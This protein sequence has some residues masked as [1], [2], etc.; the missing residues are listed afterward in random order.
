MSLNTY[1]THGLNILVDADELS[2]NKRKTRSTPNDPLVAW[3]MGNVD[4]WEQ[5]RNSNY[6]NGDL[7]S[8]TYSQ[9]WDEYWR[10]FRTEWSGED[11]QRS[12][13]RSRIVPST[14]MQA[15]DSAVAELQE[16]TFSR[17]A[18]FDTADDVADEARE[19]ITLMA[20]RLRE[21]MDFADVPDEIGKAYLYAA[22]FGTGIL[23]VTVSTKPEYTPQGMVMRDGSAVLGIKSSDIVTVGAV[24]VSPREFVIDP[25]ASI[26]DEALG[27]AHIVTVPTHTVHEK[28]Q[29]G[30]YARVPLGTY[31]QEKQNY[32]YRESESNIQNKCKLVEYHGLVPKALLPN[33]KARPDTMKAAAEGKFDYKTDMVEAIVVIANDAACL[34]AVETPFVK[35][36]DRSIVAFQWDNIPDRFWGRGIIERGYH[37]H[38]ALQTEI[39]AR[40]DSLAL[41]SYPMMARDI[42]SIT[43]DQVKEGPQAGIVQPGREIWVSGNPNEQLREFRFSGPDPNTYRATADYERMIEQATGTLSYGGPTASAVNSTVGGMSMAMG[44]FL[45][46]TK[47]TAYNV[48]RNLLK[49]LVEK[50]AFRYMQFRPD[51]YP[52]QD[53]KFK[54]LGTMGIMAREAEQDLMAQILRTVPQDSPAYYVILRLILENGALTEKP[55]LLAVVDALLQASLNPPPAPPDLSGEARMLSAQQRVQEHQD[56]VALRHEELKRKDAELMLRN[57]E[58]ELV[59][60]GRMAQGIVDAAKA[61]SEAILNIAKAEAAEVG[62]QVEQYKAIVESLA[63]T[64]MQVSTGVEPTEPQKPEN[65]KALEEKIEGLLAEVADLRKIKTTKGKDNAGAPITIQR[66]Q[67]G[68]VTSINGRKAK[69]D[70]NGL[71]VGL[72]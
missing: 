3:V 19:D 25:S 8:A 12:I 52:V 24:A 32:N 69:R 53:F 28:Q 33:V 41:S 16:A 46:R 48:E 44:S 70:A 4:E 10:I 68:L 47:K 66:D 17:P 72:E 55:E 26:I 2:R 63:K 20:E 54:V 37:G 45:K 39:R 9:N 56:D 71:L 61:E 34:K 35:K 27:C 51:R 22:I 30:I 13:E 29:R 49:P 40:A 23:K 6:L 1:D 67:R 62:S 5:H 38:K 50:F 60:Q 15:V 36:N 43:A 7:L 65:T 11:K 31:V 18:W 21:D 64:P 59:Q 57:K 14:L 42:A 58:V